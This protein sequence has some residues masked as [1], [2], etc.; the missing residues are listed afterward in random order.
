MIKLTNLDR[1]YIDLKS[2]LQQAQ[3][4]VLQSG[5]VMLGTFT[6]QLEQAIAKHSGAKYCAVVGSGSDALMYGLRASGVQTVSMPAQSYIA[7]PNSASRADLSLI[8][9]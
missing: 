2:Q 5:S 7:T 3:E 6:Q 1:L 4:Q 9:I 8:H